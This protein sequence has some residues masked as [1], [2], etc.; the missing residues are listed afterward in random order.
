MTLHKHSQ[1]LLPND[2]SNE[3]SS[4]DWSFLKS[5]AIVGL[6]TT[7]PLIMIGIFKGILKSTMKP[8]IF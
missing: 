5:F 6:I 7:L 3:E 4:H 1:I 2:L 8:T